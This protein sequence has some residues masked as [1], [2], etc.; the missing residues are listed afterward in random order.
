MFLIYLKYLK[1]AIPKFLKVT[2]EIMLSRTANT[3]LNE[4][5]ISKKMNDEYVS[6][7]AL[8]TCYL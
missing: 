4:A 2:V 3:T 7:R 5:E 1:V 8:N 6:V